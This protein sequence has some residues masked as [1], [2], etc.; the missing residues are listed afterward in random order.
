MCPIRAFIQVCTFETIANPP[1]STTTL[2]T[3]GRVGAGCMSIAIMG[4]D[5]TLIDICAACGSLAYRVAQVAV[6]DEG[7]LGVLA[8]PAQTD[9]RV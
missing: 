4:S 3:A 7:S 2:E 8:V 1:R 6:T 5:F 9:V